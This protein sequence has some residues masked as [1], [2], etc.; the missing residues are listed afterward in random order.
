MDKITVQTDSYSR[1]W[2]TF[3]LVVFS[4]IFLLLTGANMVW[5][6][7]NIYWLISG[8]FLGLMG[9]QLFAMSFLFRRK[10]VKYGTILVSKDA[11]IYKNNNESFRMND[12]W[13]GFF[14]L[15]S[16]VTNGN[17]PSGTKLVVFHEPNT[18]KT[19]SIMCNKCPLRNDSSYVPFYDF[20]RKDIAP[21]VFKYPLRKTILVEAVSFGT[22]WVESHFKSLHPGKSDNLKNPVFSFS[23]GLL[24]FV[25][26]DENENKFWFVNI[27]MTSEYKS[28][29]IKVW[30]K[31]PPDLSVYEALNFDPEEMFLISE[32]VNIPD[33]IKLFK[34]FHG[35]IYRWNTRG[36]QHLSKLERIYE[37]TNF[38]EFLPDS[39]KNDTEPQLQEQI[40]L[41]S[42]ENRFFR[43]WLKI[44]F[45]VKTESEFNKSDSFVDN[46][47]IFHDLH[48]HLSLYLSHCSNKKDKKALAWL[49]QNIS[50]M[51]SQP[52]TPAE[53][54][55][56]S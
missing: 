41:I 45:G 36:L 56:I 43:N 11:L 42:D 25:G 22:S 12:P 39:P 48:R 20:P 5:H 3:F 29:F 47:I 15:N 49:V 18:G 24:N 1:M 52:F 37:N 13:R 26:S 55:Q 2:I 30:I 14:T 6:S 9:I 35:D 50:L 34:Y 46:L 27:S 8:V 53:K 51:C 19:V 32:T 28:E 4:S 17:I 54:N 40:K 33:K 23:S 44:R 21:D 16:D 31:T 7:K 10:I 38:T